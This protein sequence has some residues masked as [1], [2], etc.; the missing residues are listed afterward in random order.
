MDPKDWLHLLHH[1][2]K[3]TYVFVVG[4]WQS[5]HRDNYVE[6]QD[7]SSCVVGYWLHFNWQ[8]ALSNKVEFQW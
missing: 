1:T 4:V 2:Q 5:K 8:L 6:N 7:S 3:A